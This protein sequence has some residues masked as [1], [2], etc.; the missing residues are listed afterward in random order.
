MANAEEVDE[1]AAYRLVMEAGPPEVAATVTLL[2]GHVVELV[3]RRDGTAVWVDRTC[4]RATTP[5]FPVN[6]VP[7][8]DEAVAAWHAL[9]LD[10]H[11]YDFRTGLPAVAREIREAEERLE[12]LRQRRRSLV[13]LARQAGMSHKDIAALSGITEKSSRKF[14]WQGKDRTDD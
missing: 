10:L 6:V 2:E 13:T 9:T 7:F 4:R 5:D 14:A 1:A 11:R 8:T 12:D 3:T